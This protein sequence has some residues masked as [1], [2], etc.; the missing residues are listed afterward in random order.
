MSKTDEIDDFGVL[1][2]SEELRGI[3]PRLKRVQRAVLYVMTT[4]I[5]M[6][7]AVLIPQIV[8][9]L[10]GR[11][12][13]AWNLNSV[14][15]PVVSA[16]SVLFLLATVYYCRKLMCLKRYEPSMPKTGIYAIIVYA[17]SRVCLVFLFKGDRN[18]IVMVLLF[19]LLLLVVYVRMLRDSMW[20]LTRE[21]S[22]AAAKRWK[23]LFR[24]F[25]VI[26][27]VSLLSL[28][29]M[30]YL[31]LDFEIY[32]ARFVFAMIPIALLVVTIVFVVLQCM[33]LYCLEKA[34][35]VFSRVTDPEIE[36]ED[37]EDNPY[38]K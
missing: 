6:I 37:D 1:R 26:G 22:Y 2:P 33:E 13:P 19:W 27:I 28:M 21:V 12:G 29:I 20:E 24:R 31:S 11:F 4:N 17:A 30:H 23:D 16:I 32:P 38:A 5:L 18:Y 10:A 3:V 14:A 36:A 7:A 34:I 8:G 15:I 35:Q 9:R 25:L